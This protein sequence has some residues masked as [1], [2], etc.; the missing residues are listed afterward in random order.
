MGRV[1]TPP[2]NS[3]V[4]ES[5]CPF[6][7]TFPLFG[8]AGAKSAYPPP[9]DNHGW[10]A[11]VELNF[12]LI[13]GERNRY[14]YSG[15]T[16]EGGWLT[17][18]SLGEARKSMPTWRVVRSPSSRRSYSAPSA[19][20][21]FR[22]IEPPEVGPMLGVSV[23]PITSPIS[24]LRGASPVWASAAVAVRK[25]RPK[26]T[27]C[28]LDLYIF[29]SSPIAQRLDSATGFSRQPDQRERFVVERGESMRRLQI[30]RFSRAR[31]LAL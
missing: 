16:A 30:F 24:F 11:R 10:N 5:P 27:A 14:A 8:D 19:R 26:R 28:I 2:P 4:P 7:F 21:E 9:N 22:L 13:W 23:A 15:L 17:F 6:T 29:V 1:S 12:T 3:S 25:A 31:T 18:T 20:L